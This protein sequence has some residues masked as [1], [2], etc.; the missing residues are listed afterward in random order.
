MDLRA[1][2]S[3]LNAAALL[4]PRVH[5]VFVTTASDQS[6]RGTVAL[7]DE[8]RRRAPTVAE[9][10][11]VPTVIVTQYQNSV[12]DGVVEDAAARLTGGRPALLHPRGVL[13]RRP[14]LTGATPL[15]RR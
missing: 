13:R 3:E 6:V 12:H 9:G 11:P 2:A 7:L 4:D 1:G 10:D 8:V 14:A 5:R 15:S